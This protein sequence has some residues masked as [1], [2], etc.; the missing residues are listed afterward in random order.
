[1]SDLKVVPAA[2]WGKRLN[3]IN[4]M[5]FAKLVAE[6]VA[7]PMSYRELVEATGLHYCTIREHVV[8]LHREGV[9]HI[10][11]YNKDCRDR[12][13]ERLWLFGAKRD[14]KR[15]R[16]SHTERQRRCRAKA[17]LAAQLGLLREA[18]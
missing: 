10:A 18:A 7:A 16:L 9:I 3:R 13:N 14:A 4:A 2:P 6:L 11:G 8:A 17:K 5:S 12:D 1:M 15:T